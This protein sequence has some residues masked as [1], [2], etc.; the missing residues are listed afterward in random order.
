VPREQTTQY[1][2]WESSE[3]D[4]D[5][6]MPGLVSDSEGEALFSAI[7]TTV[8]DSEGEAFQAGN[9]PW[10]TL[11]AQVVHDALLCMDAKDRGRAA[12]VSRGWCWTVKRLSLVS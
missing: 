10:M 4:T 9:A 2:E 8:S 12:E 7:V 3:G 5:P 6:C 11:P 1:P